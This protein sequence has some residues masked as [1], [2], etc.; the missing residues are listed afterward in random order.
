M[1]ANANPNA[2]TNATGASSR[3]KVQNIP[4]RIAAAAAAAMETVIADVTCRFLVVD[5]SRTSR[6]VTRHMLEKQ[7]TPGHHV[8][9][10]VDGSQG[11]TMLQQS[12]QASNSYDGTSRELLA[13][14]PMDVSM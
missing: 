14:L 1:N 7:L 2:N 3:S 4:N 12:M 6:R 9:E 8:D 11:V 13:L 10:A 5:D